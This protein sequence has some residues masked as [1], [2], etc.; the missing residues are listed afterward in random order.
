MLINKDLYKTQLN[1]MY[2]NISFT[3][4]WND[5]II[6]FIFWGLK[7]CLNFKY[8]IVFQRYLSWDKKWQ[9]SFN[10]TENLHIFC[11]TVK[12]Q[13]L[14]ILFA[15]SPQDISI[16]NFKSLPFPLSK[17]RAQNVLNIIWARSTFIVRLVA[18]H[19]HL[20]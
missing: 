11:F 19:F 16:P 3:W 20:L 1:K 5:N 9:D 6:L 15:K 10:D 8:W 2:E 7:E 18:T 12:T 4:S 14:Q 17:N 13:L